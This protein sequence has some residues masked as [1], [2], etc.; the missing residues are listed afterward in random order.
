MNE[1][2]KRWLNEYMIIWDLPLWFFFVGKNIHLLLSNKLTINIEKG[3][4]CCC[5]SSVIRKYSIF[6]NFRVHH[7]VF[8]R[9]DYF[10]NDRI[11]EKKCEKTKIFNLFLFLY[12]KQRF[13]FFP[14]LFWMS[15]IF[16]SFPVV[17]YESFDTHMGQFFG[18][19]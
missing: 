18:F 7:C 11:K 10:D 4:C 19:V 2:M 9:F 16:A 3:L 6:R 12:P 1:W 17:K 5:C 15:N 8:S 13:F 14:F